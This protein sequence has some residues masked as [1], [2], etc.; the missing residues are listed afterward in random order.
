MTSIFSKYTYIIQE[1]TATYKNRSNV[2][3]PKSFLVLFVIRPFFLPP[4]HV[5]ADLF[6]SLLKPLIGLDCLKAE[7]KLRIQRTLEF[8]SFPMYKI[9][10]EKENRYVTI[11]LKHQRLDSQKVIV[12]K[13]KR[14]MNQLSKKHRCVRFVHKKLSYVLCS[15]TLTILQKFK[16]YNHFRFLK[17]LCF[18]KTNQQ[19]AWFETEGNLLFP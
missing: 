1:T 13:I 11:P 15:G 18:Q 5:T 16:K 17:E 9:S 4:C 10:Q 19:F 12:K 3:T 7:I 14:H 8:I 6:L 2:N